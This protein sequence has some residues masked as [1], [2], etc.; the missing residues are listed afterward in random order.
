M[1]NGLEIIKNSAKK[2]MKKV[3]K[4]IVKLL[5]PILLLILLVAIILGGFIKVLTDEDAKYEEGNWKS[6]PF[7]STQYTTS[8]VIDSQG[9][10]NVS[11]SAQEIWDKLIE[12]DSRV[13]EYLDRPEEL[14]KLMNAELITN[15]PDTRLNPDEPIDWDTLNKDINSKKGQGIIKFKRAKSDGTSTRITFVDS[16][17]Y[18]E[19]IEAYNANGDEEALDNVLNHF[20]IEEDFSIQ[21]NF[22][23]DD[24]TADISNAI[25]QASYSTPTRGPGLC[26]AWV[27]RVYANAGLGDVGYATAYEAFKA[28]VVSTDMNNIPIG[29]AVY[30]TG[31]SYAGHVGIY[32]GNGKVRDSITKNGAGYIN[33]STLS[34]WLSWQTN[35]IDG[36]TGWLGWGWQAGVATI[37]N[38]G[39][40]VD[41]TNT[42][43]ETTVQQKSYSVVVGT[44]KSIRKIVESNDPAVSESDNTDYMMTTQSINYLSLMSGYIM[45]FDY[46]WSLLV[47]GRQKEF[48]LELAD[49]VYDSEIEIT[50]YDNWNKVTEAITNKYVETEI[51]V[52]IDTGEEREISHNYYRT[53]T[54]ITQNNT[55]SIILSKAD[56][57]IADY[58]QEYVYEVPEKQTEGPVTISEGTTKTTTTERILYNYAPA[59]TIEKTDI[60]SNEPNFVNIFMKQEYFKTRNN[61]FSA[62]DWLYEILENNVKTADMV[63]LTKY[64][65]YKA[66]GQNYGVTE[67]DSS[68]FDPSDFSGISTGSEGGLSLT[69]TMFTKEEFKQAMQVYYDKTGNHNF[70]NNFLSKVDELYDAS[71]ANNINPELVVITAKAEG[72]FSES[73][74]R[75]NYWGIGVPNGASSGYT[76]NSLTEGITGYANII[77]SYETGNYAAMIIQK[78]QERKEAGCDPLGYGLPGTMSGMQSIYSYLGKHEYGSSGAGGYYYMDPARAGVTKIY[79]THEEFLEKC[80]NSGLPEHA[81][82]TETTVWEQGQ[83]TAWQVEI[84]L[85]TWDSIFGDY[86]DRSEIAK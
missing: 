83:Y 5:L 74:G 44:P 16:E 1:N 8:A 73:G 9:N 41:G 45:P 48:V 37:E 47:T 81:S 71:I 59:T 62:P 67:P 21:N 61:I 2:I 66:T 35:T 25:V 50:I 14:L 36:K 46:L 34:E 38:T 17:T 65:F 52:D 76:Y 28:N 80:Q 6:I 55:L 56:V 69:T 51:V 19:W 85:Q 32:I 12:E 30:G 79:K 70:Y 22:S 3:S 42:N 58:S 26:Q 27:R 43:E 68:F 20:T 60:N 13:K 78:Y 31:T 24:I 18:Y 39:E 82:G 11:M 84:K 33:E 23:T 77:H 53:N 49:L 63:D 72:N 64:L 57:W 40:Q 86:G 75:Y 4:K 15:F 29:A 54:T 10:I 7:A